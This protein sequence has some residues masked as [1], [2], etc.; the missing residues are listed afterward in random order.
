MSEHLVQLE[1]GL[2]MDSDNDQT[3]SVLMHY[4]SQQLH[5]HCPNLFVLQSITN[6]YTKNR[7][8]RHLL[9]TVAKYNRV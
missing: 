3:F 1:N 7:S 5:E 8:R 6:S 2:G 9:E 4:V